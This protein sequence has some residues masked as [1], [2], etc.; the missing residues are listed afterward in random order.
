MRKLFLVFVLSQLAMLSFG[1]HVR[2][3]KK[4]QKR[5]KINS[6][7]KQEEEGII[8]Y[9]HQFVFGAKLTNDGYGGFLEYGIAKSL[10][11][12]LLFQLEMTERKAAKEEK[13]SFGYSGISPIIYGKQNFVYPIKLGMQLQS[14]LGNKSN[15]N[16]VSV[17]ANYGGGLALALIRPYELQTQSGGNTKYITYNSADSTTFLNGPLSGGPTFGTGWSKSTVAPGVYVKTALRFDYGAYNEVV[18]ALECGLTA[19][20]YGQKIPI[21]I[22]APAKNFFFSAYAAIIFG[23]RR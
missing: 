21:M 15:K 22:H 4:E 16:G 1:Q 3:T 2:I 18:S 8:V 14:V 19:E 13:Q 10:K 11:K 20:Y 9:H 5:K 6:I 7:V 23:K 12:S 17:T